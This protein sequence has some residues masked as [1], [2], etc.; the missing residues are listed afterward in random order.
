MPVRQID[1]ALSADLRRQLFRR[2]DV[3]QVRVTGVDPGGKFH[4]LA[5]EQK[6]VQGA[7]VAIEPRTGEV[8]AMVGGYDFDD[9]KFNR[10]TQALRQPGS[11]FKPLIYTAALEEGMTPASMVLD[12]PLTSDVAGAKGW[13]PENYDGKYHGPI[14]LRSALT[15]SRNLPTV[16][17]L[18]KVGLPTACA[19]VKRL[20]ITSAVGCYPSLALGA[21]GVTLMD[22]TAAYGTF[23]NGGIYNEPVVITKIANWK[24]KVLLERFQDARQA[25]SPEVAYLMTSMMQS[26]IQHGTARALR[27]LERPAA[28]KTGTTNDYDDAWFVGYTPELVTGVWVGGTITNPWVTGKLGQ[29]RRAYLA[30]LYEG[31]REGPTHYQLSYPPWRAVCAYGKPR[32][33]DT[34]SGVLC[35]RCRAV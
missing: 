8:K 16:R 11:S 6:P 2:G 9:S 29:G 34:C 20:G 14:T 19:T 10:A 12:A 1:P 5:L 27:V 7:L 15:H 32:Q 31:G 24:G 21:S 18:D 33:H 28:G 4:I 25:T 23:A 35:R 13:R 30:G 17:L 22:L 26:V 3:I